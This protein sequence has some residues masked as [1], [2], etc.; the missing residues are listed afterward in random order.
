MEAPEEFRP[1]LASTLTSVRPYRHYP[2]RMSLRPRAHYFPTRPRLPEG[3]AP[4]LR[5]TLRQV[6]KGECPWPLLIHGP[7]GVG[8]TCAALCLL[9][10]AGGMYWS[11]SELPALIIDCHK[12]VARYP[13]GAL[14]S[15]AAL[16]REVAD[17]AL[18]VLDEIGSGV[19]S[20]FHRT[21]IQQVLDM[22]EGRP[23]VC[24]SNLDLEAIA[25]T[26]DDRIASRLAAGTVA[27][28]AG[29]DLRLEGTSGT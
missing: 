22:R 12:G 7:A 29:R 15:A 8:K 16:W 11:A 5:R 4:D 18:V 6:V 1:R 13:S 23:L 26:H 17:T 21:V 20:D 25:L 19:V 27:H 28:L 10:H 9:D 24:L 14:L 3:I 2:L